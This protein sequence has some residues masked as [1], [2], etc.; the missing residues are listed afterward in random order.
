MSE[1]GFQSFPEFKTVRTYT[2]AED[3]DINS[4]VMSAHQRSGIGNELIKMYMGWDYKVPYKF[5]HILYLS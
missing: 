4:N 2:V 1:Y 5:E 3:W